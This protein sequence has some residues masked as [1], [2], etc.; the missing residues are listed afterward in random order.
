MSYIIPSVLVYQQ[1]ANAGGVANSTPDLEACIIGPAYNVLSYV[2]GNT[3]SLIKT[4]ATSAATAT[5]SI[6]SGSALLTF[7]TIP[8][9]TIGDQLLVAGADASG[10]ALQA[11]VIDALGAVL[12]L[13]T[14][15]G[16]TVTGALVNKQG[17]IVNPLI[18]NTF[19]L[20]G[21]LPGQIIDSTSIQVY[22]NES[23]IQTLSTGVNGYG[24]NS[25]LTYSAANTTGTAT[26][27]SAVLTAVV[28][29]SKFTVGDTISVAGAGLA[30]VAL[31]AKVLVIGSGTMTLDTP[32]STTVASTAITKIAIS[33]ISSVTSTLLVE[34]GD[35]VEIAYT[36]TDSSAHVVESIVTNVIAASGIIT[37]L[38]I[39]DVLPAN[40]SPT[41]TST[42]GITAG[43]S[44]FSL[45]SATGFAIGDT[46]L[47][48]G[49]G[50]G[51]TDLE[52]TIGGLTGSVVSALSPVTSTT[53]SSG[54]IIQKR[55]T[56]TFRTRKLF[57]NQAVPAIKPISGGANYNVS[58]TAV[59]GTITINPNPEIIYGKL[60]S[61]EVYIAYNAM[62]TDL[63]GSIMTIND[64]NDNLGQFGVVNEQNPLALGC[65]IALANTTTRVRAIALKTNDEAGYL[66][67]FDLA[68]SERVYALAVMTQSLSTGA[69]LANHVKGLSV[70][71][72]ALWRVG[73]F[74]SVIPTTIPVGDY[75]ADL[76]N[77]NSGNNSI[78]LNTGKYVLT[79]SNA[80]FIS[81]NVTPG[82]TINI[83]A[84]TGTPS[85][86]GTMQILNVVSNQQ[87]VVQASGIATGIGYYIT[88]TLSKT[89]RA[90]AVAATST[91][92]SS[93][94]I[95][96]VQPDL[97]SVNV[98][99]SNI[100]LPGYYLCCALAGL[101]AGFPSQQGFTNI[102]IAG[103]SDLHNSNFT[104][105][106]A[107]LNTM[108]AAGTLLYI[109]ETPG[110][111]PYIRHEL[112]TDM[113]VYQYRELQAV[114]NWDFLSYYYYDK[115]KPFI[116][117][118]NITPDTL[119]TIRQ[120]IVASSEL[121]KSKKLPKIGAPLLG[122]TIQQL[123][124]DPV[125]TD[126]VILKLQTL[127]PSVLNY[128]DLYLII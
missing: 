41:T 48:H 4:A 107:Q 104:F 56:V 31:V 51:G 59:D 29:D 72:E 106:R 115:M 102:G 65:Q 68:E 2:A 110:G 6:T 83:T 9:F 76:V 86:I 60:I 46:I 53:V 81:D 105:T 35:A 50:P 58:N 96:H 45:T 126:H 30:G 21:Q 97:V 52:A 63:S 25:S 54:A 43:A 87:L 44:T 77:I 121:L 127:Q 99:G 128:L 95:C 36:G 123:I 84:G 124:Q 22:V 39:S 79:A 12:T 98:N 70:P 7:V 42:A 108:A 3:A 1:L 14:T 69:A 47:I 23:L 16:T 11:T 109:Q 89:Q 88:R 113:S 28:D 112:T 71:E 118:W 61:G 26:S 101:T 8:P 15:A 125:N 91:T 13:S 116:G 74:N 20:P 24:G 33:N 37:N 119:G 120:T 17:F 80:T 114:K 57:N 100:V 38:T 18:S 117:S 85:P 78:T 111:I 93:N 75:T 67:A 92:F 90:A 5:A 32:A 122:Y 10:G 66:E 19:N 103:V 49:A 94:R 82:D 34:A 64:A 27:T 73:Y 62:R 40:V 55:A